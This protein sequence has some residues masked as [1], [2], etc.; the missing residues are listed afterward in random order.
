MEQLSLNQINKI[1]LVDYLA[2]LGIQPKKRKAHIH[3]Y[4]SPLPGH[5]T[6]RPT[7]IVNRHQNRWRETTTRQTGR[8]ADLAVNLYDC[9]IG[10]LTVKLR[11][12][13][14]PVSRDQSETCPISQPTITVERTHPIRS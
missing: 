8:L 3:Y 12:V 4:C 1:D 13:L 10:E 11:A 7:F 6:S 5:P 14:P 2:T 9:T